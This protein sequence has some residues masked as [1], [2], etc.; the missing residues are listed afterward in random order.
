MQEGHCLVTRLP[1]DNIIISAK[2]LRRS[3]GSNAGPEREAPSHYSDSIVALQSHDREI[4]SYDDL[5][6]Q[7]VVTKQKAVPRPEPGGSNMLER[8]GPL[9]RLLILI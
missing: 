3:Q 8:K 2:S 7:T 5:M 6:I 9:M 4:G 1:V